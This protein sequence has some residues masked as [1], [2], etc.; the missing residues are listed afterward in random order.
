LQGRHVPAARFRGLAIAKALAARG[1]EVS[2]RI[3]VPSVYGDWGPLGRL[4]G[5]RTLAS[6]LAVVSRLG[7]L[8]DL[9]PDDFI[10]FQRPMLEL[11]TCRLESIAATGRESLFDFDDA[12]YLNRATRRKFPRIVEMVDWVVAGNR[13]LAEAADAPGKTVVIPTVVDT[14]AW[15]RQATRDTSGAQV[16][17][18]WTGLAS[19]YRQL[20]IAAP[21]IARALERTGAKFMVIAD[22]PPPSALDCLRAEFVRWSPRREVDDLSR[23]DI[24]VMPLPDGPYERGKC[25]FKL[26]QY[27]ALG[28]PALASP[29]GANAEV[30]TDGSDGF[31][32]R[33]AGAWEE[34]LTALIADPA[35]RDA[36]GTRARERIVSG[37]SVDAVVPRYLKILQGAGAR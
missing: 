34:Q 37:Y 22:A 28:R 9:R 7:Q 10:F 15:T 13:H 12:I 11:P 30:V 24:G 4:P 26:I 3:A 31:L 25:A 36:V 14:T 18:G 32:P 20:A 33:D 16:V 8:R 21:G 23:M 6:P 27:M 19:N 5:L 35:Q 1:T 29:V 17:V 2:C